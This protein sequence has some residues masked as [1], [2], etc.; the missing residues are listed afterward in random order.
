MIGSQAVL[1]QYPEEGRLPDAMLRSNEIDIWPVEKPELA[2][3]I[4][5]T[6]GNGSS[7]HGV[8]GYY[9]D[10]V[11]PETALLPAHWMDRCIRK[12]G[13]PALNGAI[14]ICPEIHDLAASK[15]AAFRDKDLTWVAAAVR[16]GLVD[17]DLLLLRVEE[18]PDGPNFSGNRRNAVINWMQNGFGERDDFGPR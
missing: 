16:A 5:G 1:L 12:S 14:A 13:H 6:L 10:G 8:F 17:K 15:I 18:I 4:E 3:L 11:G 7:F 2:D 9:A